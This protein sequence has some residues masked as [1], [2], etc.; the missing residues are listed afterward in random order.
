MR[1]K[2]KFGDIEI[3]VDN[4]SLVWDDDIY[5]GTTLHTTFAI[6]AA[7]TFNVSAGIALSIEHPRPR[8]L[9]G[10][11]FANLFGAEGG[12]FTTLESR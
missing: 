3:H 5:M 8:F 2:R 10:I 7:F 4:G 1:I 9:F 12:L 6:G 11:D